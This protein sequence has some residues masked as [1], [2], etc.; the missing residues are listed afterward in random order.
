MLAPP[1]EGICFNPKPAW[2]LTSQRV[3]YFK[4][5]K[6]STCIHRPLDS[7]YYETMSHLFFIRLMR[8][9]SES[10]NEWY[11]HE[12]WNLQWGQTET[13]RALNACP[14]SCQC[15]VPACVS[16]IAPSDGRSEEIWLSDFTAGK[17]DVSEGAQW[18]LDFFAPKGEQGTLF[19]L[20]P[21]SFALSV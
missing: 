1:S 17:Q 2:D 21:C 5:F 12:R 19:F 6:A 15:T 14:I 18:Q 7:K 10:D 16:K 9:W 13:S 8:M 20:F 3:C 11:L 4:E